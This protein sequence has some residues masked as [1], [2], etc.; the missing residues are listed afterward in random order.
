MEDE[1]LKRI[2]DQRKKDK[3]EEKL[4]RQ[5][6]LDLI[7]RDRQ[8]RKEK[9]SGGSQSQESPLVGGTNVSPQ[10]SAASVIPV[11]QKKSYDETK[12]QLRLPS[13]QVL[14][15]TFGCKERL[16]NVRLY[17]ELNSEVKQPFT[18]M[19]NFPKTIFTDDDMEKPLYDLGLVPTAVL[20][21]SKRS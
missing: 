19:T 21:V 10:P 9:F 1:E 11:T 6:A 15:Q 3:L 12:I 16:A 5:R 4:A 7:E 2:V 18:L 17:V 20:I 8:A 13:G 14:T